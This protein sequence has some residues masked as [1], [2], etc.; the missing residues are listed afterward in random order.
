MSASARC[1]S[2]VSVWVASS[3]AKPLWSRLGEWKPELMGALAADEMLVGRDDRLGVVVLVKSVELQR[4]LADERVLS[5]CES[6]VLEGCGGGA[7]WGDEV[8]W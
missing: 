8:G 4:A 1:S 7:R 5:W 6:G 2:R 3:L